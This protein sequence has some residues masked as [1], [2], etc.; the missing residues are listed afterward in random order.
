MQVTLSWNEVAMASDVGRR[1]QLSSLRQG[2]TDKH[3]FSGDGW[4][5][6][7]EGALGEMAVA[8]CLGIY[9]D[10]SVNTFKA[11]DLPGLQ[12]RTR[13]QHTYD[14][15]IRRDDPPGDR[16]LLV[17]GRCP[18]YSLRG[19]IAG[20]DGQR[21]EYLA[22]HGGRERAFFVPPSA[23]HDIST[24]ILRPVTKLD[25]PITTKT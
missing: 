12:V 22:A 11:N 21:P 13:S 2:L 16:Y 24:L 23:L 1:R 17:T 18:H 7:I 6:H 3:G 10:G 4:G 14:L 25:G 8:K 20:A 9:W 5:A 19:W 15:I